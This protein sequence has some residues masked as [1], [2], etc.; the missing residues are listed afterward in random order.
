MASNSAPNYDEDIIK[1]G[2]FIACYER[3]Q[4]YKYMD[5]LVISCSSGSILK[6]G[7]ESRSKQD[8]KSD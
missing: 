7:I 8:H 6:N 1:C 2:D 3:E 4:K 5:Q